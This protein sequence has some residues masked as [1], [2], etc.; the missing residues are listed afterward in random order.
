MRILLPAF[1]A[2]LILLLVLAVGVYFGWQGR[3]Q[4]LPSAAKWWQKGYEVQEV[5]GLEFADRGRGFTIRRLLLRLNNGLLLD[6]RDLHLTQWPVWTRLSGKPSSIDIREIRISPA[7]A[8]T[9]IAPT[10]DAQKGNDDS[11]AINKRPSTTPHAQ[12]HPATPP[13]TLSQLLQQL[14][15]LP[16]IAGNIRNLYWEEKFSGALNIALTKQGSRIT[17]AFKHRACDECRVDITLNNLL[18]QV[19]LESTFG[20]PGDPSLQAVLKLAKLPPDTSGVDVRWNSALSLN[21]EAQRIAI[22][23][24]SWEKLAGGQPSTQLSTDIASGNL[25]LNATA[26]TTD[27]IDYPTGIM[28]ASLSLEANN[29]EMRLP[30]SLTGLMLPLFVSANS[31]QPMRLEASRLRPLQVTSATG[32]FTLMADP[33]QGSVQESNSGPEPF[34]HGELQLTSDTVSKVS[35]EGDTNIARTNGLIPEQIRA[36]LL[37]GYSLT[38]LGGFLRVAGSADLPSPQHLLQNSDLAAR[39]IRIKIHRQGEISAHL[40]PRASNH[41]LHSMGLTA[42]KVLLQFDESAQVQALSWPGK[43]EFK[44]PTLSLS[45]QNQGASAQ[46]PDEAPP[47][48]SARVTGLACDDLLEASCTFKIAGKLSKVS[49]T[50]GLSASGASI[51]LSAVLNRQPADANNT[52]IISAPGLITLSDVSLAADKFTI[53]DIYARQPEL[54]MQHAA[55]NRKGTRLHCSTAQAAISVAPLTLAENSVSGVIHLADL[56]LLHDSAQERISLESAFRSDSLVVAVHKQIQLDLRSS[57]K[58]QLHDEQVTG[59]GEIQAG[60]L[61]LNNSWQHNLDS[62]NGQVTI[63]IPQ[64]RFS[65]EQPLSE[66]V[67]GLPI[68]IVDGS[69]AAD[70]QFFWPDTGKRVKGQRISVKLDSV[71]AT[72]NDIVAVGVDGDFSLRPSADGWVT[73]KTSPVFIQRLDAGIP[74]DNLRFGLSLDK[75]QDVRLTGFSGEML[76]GALTSDSLIWNL[77][78]EERHSEVVF[79]GL[80]LQSLAKEMESENFV[81]TGLL[82]ARLPLTTDRQ[83]VT[84]ENGTLDARAPGGRLRYY[85]AFSPSM[86]TS[87]PQLKLLAGALEDYNY[88]AIHGTITYPLSGDLTLNLKLTGRSDAVDANRDLVI[89]LNLENNVPSMLKSLQASRDLTDV[90]EKAVQ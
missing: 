39:N 31:K 4:W 44:A 76:E 81:A 69:I 60:N 23:L 82:D 22:L 50:S 54:F 55:C 61:T 5:E 19:T 8:A 36:T 79:T 41:A 18:D 53:N 1:K 25:S 29:L 63:K 13:A 42:P 88:R 56:K 15:D 68:D 28:N 6:A 46:T 77:N 48:I 26:E 47:P 38:D 24:D 34:I 30:E 73:E 37:S 84:V 10:T 51:A 62:G 40:R 74:V 27:I 85:G 59:S 35:F 16:L 9:G 70:I 12:G 17:G 32:L 11:A 7:E 71:S 64:A 86:L 65:P 75:N 14:H 43:L 66:T 20:E 78:G 58:F 80:S 67:K 72:Y 3:H 87:N 2:L 49:L 21:A 89:N 90:L 45:A 57:G 33:E 52:Q 83:G